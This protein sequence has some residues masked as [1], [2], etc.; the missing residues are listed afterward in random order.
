MESA[1]SRAKETARQRLYATYPI[2]AIVHMNVVCPAT[3]TSIWESCTNKVHSELFGQL[4]EKARLLPIEQVE[5][6][7][8]DMIFLRVSQDLLALAKSLLKI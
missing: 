1:F 5:K 7:T 2:E 4:L 3:R 8:G 6:E